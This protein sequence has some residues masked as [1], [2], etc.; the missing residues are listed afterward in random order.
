M[1][2]QYIFPPTVYKGSNFST[3]LPTLVISCH[4]DENHFHRGEVI[5]HCSFDLH[6][7][8][9]SLFLCSLALILGSTAPTETYFP[10][11]IKENQSHFL[12]VTD[13]SHLNGLDPCT[14]GTIC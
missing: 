1:A 4:T 9:E 8:I 7:P 3:S 10:V 13:F 2:A 12:K 6:F 5:S 14:F 11:A